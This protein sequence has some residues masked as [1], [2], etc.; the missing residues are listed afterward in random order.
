MR[1][2]VETTIPD[3][4]EQG[5]FVIN[6][7]REQI[8]INGQVMKTGAI[9][10]PLTD[11]AV[12]EK[13]ETVIFWWRN[14]QALEYIPGDDSRDLPWWWGMVNSDLV[15]SMQ[16]YLQGKKGVKRP[17]ETQGSRGSKRPKT[18]SQVQSNNGTNPSTT[19]GEVLPTNVDDVTSQS[20]TAT[21]ATLLAPAPENGR[22]GATTKTTL[23][24]DPSQK[25]PQ[26]GPR[27]VAPGGKPTRPKSQ[28][29]GWKNF[30][31]AG[32]ARHR[33]SRQQIEARETGTFTTLEALS[34][35]DQNQVVISIA[36][37]WQGLR[38]HG[39]L[40][41]FADPDF[42]GYDPPILDLA[43]RLVGAPEKFIMPILWH[44]QP[45]KE[46]Q[47]GKETYLG[48]FV[49]FVAEWCPE[50]GEVRLE[51]FNSSTS[52]PS[53]Q[54]LVTRAKE[55]I[56][57]SH[58]PDSQA[59]KAEPSFFS[60]VRSVACPI[61]EG[62]NTCGFS[63]ILNAWCVMLGIPISPTDKRR[64]LKGSHKIFLKTGLEIVNLALKGCMD[65][66]TI[67]AFV[68]YW[69]YSQDQKYPED[70]LANNV[71]AV[72]MDGEL[73]NTALYE[74][75]MIESAIEDGVNAL[76]ES[77]ISMRLWAPLTFGYMRKLVIDANGDHNIAIEV[78]I[79]QFGKGSDERMVKPVEQT[80]EIDERIRRE[81]GGFL[82]N[83]NNTQ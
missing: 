8:F 10:G 32:L 22:N 16:Q 20:N 6:K 75:A 3:I 42:F 2:A 13:N 11:F 34:A 21:A 64:E 61:Q 43:K 5:F 62:V 73:L 19:S 78:I 23:T 1:R 44:D 82:G 38:Q 56:M 57:G 37:I 60:Y 80:D 67:Q 79:S 33:G 46:I 36:T 28:S 24:T 12:I 15:E 25:K 81:V 63:V 77:L 41:A 49:L 18:G 76:I 40:F 4:A 83:F 69:G 72:R 51:L 58:W 65:A 52:G 30:L 70:L 14:K 35:L 50:P 68:N 9:V 31:D 7:S 47:A 55:L 39:Q 71:A 59:Q 66:H 53:T 27:T 48:H 29:K 26:N 45:G 54:Q 74:Q 17:Q